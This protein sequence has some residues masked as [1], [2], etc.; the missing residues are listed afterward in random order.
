MTAQQLITEAQDDIQARITA[1]FL[2]YLV[3]FGFIASLV[4]YVL[5]P[6]RPH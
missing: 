2:L 6:R 1:A 5:W 4:L 3:G